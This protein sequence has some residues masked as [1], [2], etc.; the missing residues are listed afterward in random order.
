MTKFKKMNKVD[1]YLNSIGPQGSIQR[2]EAIAN[3]QLGQRSIAANKALEKRH[4][5]KELMDKGFSCQ[6]AMLICN[7]RTETLK[8]HG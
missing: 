3:L 1:E 6:E 8:N 4:Y 7:A 5:R 2:L